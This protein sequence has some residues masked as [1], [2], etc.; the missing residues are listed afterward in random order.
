MGASYMVTGNA[1]SIGDYLD[2]S[3]NGGVILNS[4]DFK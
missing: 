1:T 3:T 4:N 2:Q